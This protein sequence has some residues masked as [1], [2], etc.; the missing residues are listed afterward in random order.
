MFTNYS[1][2]LT[3]I[4]RV[5][6]LENILPDLDLKGR[7]ITR[8]EIN[9][10]ALQLAG[11]YYRFDN[12]RVQVIGRVEHGY[13]ESLEPEERRLAI[14][15]LFENHIPCIVICKNLEVFPEM[16]QYGMKYNVPVFRTKNTTTDFTAEM[17][18]WLRSELA[19][20][21]M[22][23]GVLVDIYGEGVLITGSS[24]IGKSEAALE[25][26]KRGHRLI[27]D[28]AVEI[29]KIADQTLVGTCP[30]LIRYMIELRGIGIINVKDLFG[31]SSVKQSKTIDLVVK[32]ESWDGTACTYDRLGLGEDYME[33][34]GNKVLCNTIPVR[35]GRNLAVICESAAINNRQKKMGQHTAREMEEKLRN[36]LDK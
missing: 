28:D 13:L 16:I 18:F 22:L 31:V 27:A 1:A 20:R 4:V 35:P 25:L 12:D 19:E 5:F 30:E 6:Q 29:K 36:Q 23:H 11:Y 2:E 9:R 14:C 21:I 7:V 10:P 3:K 34:L 26:I 24:G 17:I 15:H 32:L 8:K 33:I